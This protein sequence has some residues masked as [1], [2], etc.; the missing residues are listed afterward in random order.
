MSDTKKLSQHPSAVR[1]R[2]HRENK[3]HTTARTK[4]KQRQLEKVYRFHIVR[5]L[6]PVTKYPIPDF[7]NQDSDM[8][9]RVKEAYLKECDGP[10]EVVVEVCCG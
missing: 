10:T 6:N 8:F 5:N 4:E 7:V 9:K 1:S 3:P 2:K